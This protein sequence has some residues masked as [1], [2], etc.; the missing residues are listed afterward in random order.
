MAIVPFSREQVK[1]S[2][3]LLRRHKRFTALAII[4]LGVAIA[5]N[6]TMY[7]VVDALINPKL[8]IFEPYGLYEA[9][10]FGDYRGRVPIRERN[11]AL[12][13]LTFHA[14]AAGMRGS[15]DGS[16]IERGSRLR[17]A[18]ILTVTP[19]Y[20]A[21]LGVR[22]GAGRLLSRADVSST[23][24]TVVLSERMWRQLFPDRE[25]FDSATVLLDGEPRTVVGVLPYEAD[26][27][28]AY[29]D[30][31]QV[32]SSTALPDMPVT[33]FRLGRGMTG[34]QAI[35]ELNTLN[36]RIMERS[37]DRLPHAGFR[38]R[39]WIRPQFRAWGF[40][41]A[42]V[43]AVGAVLLI[44][45]AN[46]ANLQLA[47]G[48]ARTR[49]LAT[50]SAIGASR[51]VIISQLVL[52]SAWLALGGLLLGAVLTAWGM[53][54]V[55][56][57]VPETLAE[58]VTRP[59]TSWRVAVFAM[60]A[61][62]FCVLTVGLL[63]AIR[64]SRVDIDTLLKSGNGTGQSR[65]ARRQYAYLAVSEVTLALTLMCGAGLLIQA[66]MS[67]YRFELPAN[68]RRLA[69]THVRINPTPREVR[70][71]RLWS[72]LVLQRLRA[73][74]T[75][76]SAATAR[77]KQPSRRAIS[78]DD[79]GGAPREFATHL[80]GYTIVS[81]EYLRTLRIPILEGRDF[82]PGEFA[83]PQVI[84]DKATATYLWPG[85]SPVGRL[86]KLD[87]SRVDAPWLTVVGVSDVQPEV[88]Q[89]RG[90]QRDDPRPRLGRIWVL[91]A[92]DTTRVLAFSA[93]ASRWGTGFY[94]VAR[95]RG[96]VRRLPAAIRRALQPLAPSVRHLYTT[97][98]EDR[99]RI[100]VQREQHDFIAALFGVFA[101]CALGLAA[102]GV[103]AIVSHTVAQR[104]REFG[105]RIAVGATGRQIRELVFRDA[106][107]LALIGI[108]IG[109]LV[110]AKSGGLLRAFLFS[111]Y[112]RYDSRI[113]AVA[114]LVLFTIAWVA[115]WIPARRATR[116][117]PVEALR[118]D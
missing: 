50:R 40:H 75:V 30:V 87:S 114:A 88:W 86:I 55:E 95:T 25:T 34:A 65:R 106:N 32:A 60:A 102:L 109:L 116:I 57:S 21:L 68:Y 9:P 19:N 28:G 27:P 77:T 115:S 35:A 92:H 91:N 79:A 101:L 45:C 8:E 47:R 73:D 64:L 59:Q 98:Y 56:T 7:S 63:P 16:T 97:A 67:L 82:S 111:D 112:D 118:N 10:Y 70:S 61:T 49:E 33:L 69:M 44:A 43:G 6:T 58:Y 54:I 24:A 94:V 12:R 38:F 36:H 5:L 81:A 96:D 23:S 66:A 113:F 107:L 104:T 110:T 72:E 52:E 103:Y 41:M 99:S 37:G 22:P 71:E 93:G 78:V 117:N 48:V 62:S 39:R 74:T 89:L 14:G 90:S 2:A 100:R 53:R 31:W 20:F 3:R 1:Q 108:A 83:E 85:E 15:G 17:D 84:V 18:R 42:I 11:E 4:S 13:A 51:R 80:W 105:V 46:L 76:V 29:T 26:Y